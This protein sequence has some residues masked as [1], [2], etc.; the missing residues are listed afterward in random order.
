[1][2][3]IFI[4]LPLLI[5]RLIPRLQLARPAPAPAPPK[6]NTQSGDA[7]PSEAVIVVQSG[8][9]VIYINHAARDLFGFW[10]PD[11]NLESLARRTRPN[12]A[13]LSLCATEGQARFLLGE[14]FVE[15]A[16]FFMPGSI[17][18]DGS[19]RN[20]VLVS[21]H[22]PGL[23]IQDSAAKG[24][25]GAL[26]GTDSR[27]SIPSGGASSQTFSFFTELT[28]TM[29]ASLDLEVTL[30]TILESIERLFPCDMMEISL[31]NS[32]T[33]RL[34]PYRL[35]G[36]QG[37]ERHIEKVPDRDPAASNYSAHLVQTRE[38]LLIGDPAN[39]HSATPVL[40]TPAGE[41]RPMPYQSYLGVPLLIAGNLVG[42][43]EL[44]TLAKDSFSENDLEV[45]RL[46]AGQAAVAVNNALLYRQELHRSLELGGLA[47]L[48]QSISVLR[49]PQDLY[50]RLI[51]SIRP[52]LDV[53][54]LGFL[55]YDENRRSLEAQEPFFG[56][57]PDYIDWCRVIMQPESPAEML[58]RKGEV[59][60][61]TDAPNDP[62]IQAFELHHLAFAAGLRHTVLMPL[63][64]SG[65]TLGYLMSATRRDG[66]PFDSNDLRILAIIAGQ[67]A[68][69]IDNANLVQQSRRRAQRAETL[70]RIA[71]LTSSA[72]TLEE[73]LKFSVLDLARLLQADA[74]AL[75]L[76]DEARGELRL[77]RRAT[78]GIQPEAA[79]RIGRAS[80]EDA[81][82]GL[83]VSGSRQLLHNSDLANDPDI[84]Q[85]Y[86]PLI[87]DVKVRSAI[88]APLVIGDRS[89][90][91]LFIGS[92]RPGFFSS[93]DAQTL[94]TAAGQLAAAIERAALYSQTDQS[95]RQRVD[96]LVALTRV[97]RELNTTVKL[98]DLLQRVYDEV[99]RTTRSDCGSVLLF[100]L[101]CD[102][103]VDW[104]GAGKPKSQLPRHP[105]PIWR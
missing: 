70:R 85:F 56:V 16:S 53:E 64:S 46:L 80:V 36:V 74:A 3:L 86:R 90:G 30:Q 4:L 32:E 21:L 7:E 102:P 105:G 87:D 60:L 104:S 77:H 25:D 98:D 37:G 11:A 5:L 58:W 68:P 45:V 61:A 6:I 101:N 54:V 57:H 78:Y 69:I 103:P 76:M 26:G 92:L 40:Q 43:L 48:A 34:A 44:A 39:F 91:E 95:L 65:R 67:A 20:A 73:I 52:L 15:G 33:G 24:G 17:A 13:F 10:E 72:A 2:G 99:L 29:A 1:M 71:S 93:G 88:D 75:F 38:P 96:Q 83:L 14:R 31:W 50:S 94:T 66:A 51:D 79:A 49:D 47:E 22:R 19:G 41:R 81:Q 55:I 18:G 28:R 89:L 12:E 42:A 59:I 62:R 100:D 23:M 63:S 27:N 82:F 9:R 84:A 97:S 35:T 8:G